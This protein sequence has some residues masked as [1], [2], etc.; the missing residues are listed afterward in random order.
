MFAAFAA[1]AQSTGMTA[2]WIDDVTGVLSSLLVLPGVVAVSALL[3]PVAPLV[4][5]R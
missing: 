3:G 5:S 4:E 2:G 1:G